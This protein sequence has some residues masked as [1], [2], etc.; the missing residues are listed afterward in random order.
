MVGGYVRCGLVWFGLEGSGSNTMNMNNSKL[1][2]N[3]QVVVS[4]QDF[5]EWW[6]LCH[7]HNHQV[8]PP[9]PPATPPK[10]KTPPT[11][12][13]WEAPQ[14]AFPDGDYLLT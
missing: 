11:P 4:Y 3:S 2:N 6:H 5:I 12:P 7:N 10:A 13:P 1:I 14:P 8:K 9:A